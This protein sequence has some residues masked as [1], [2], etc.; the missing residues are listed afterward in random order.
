MLGSCMCGSTLRRSDAHPDGLQPLASGGRRRRRAVRGGARG[1]GCAP[2]A[3]RC[4]SLT[5]GVEGPDVVHTVTPWPYPIQETP[6]QPARR[7]LL[8]HAV[9]VYNPRARRGARRRCSTTLAPDVVHTPRGAGAVERRAHPPPAGTGSRTS[10]R[11]TTTGCSASATRWSTATARPA[12]PAA[13]RAPASPGSATR[14]SAG[15]PRRGARG[16]GG[17]RSRARAARV[18]ARPAPRALQPGRGRG[19][20]RAHARGD[21]RPLTFGFLGRLGVDKGVSTLLDAFARAGSRT[22]AS[23]WP[24]AG[25]SKSTSARRGRA[26]IAAGWVD[27]DA[28][29]GAARRPGLPRRAVGVEGPRAGRGERGAGAG[30]PGHRRGDRRHPR[31]DRARVPRRCCSRP[32]TPARSPTGSRRSRAAPG[33]LPARARGRADRLGRAPRRWSSRPMPTP[34]RRVPV[35]G[36]R[37]RGAEWPRSVAT[38]GA[39]APKIA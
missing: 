32:A 4:T 8:F 3:T 28:Q 35:A 14:R 19:R 34:G 21:G 15:R 13:G 39:L 27:A 25:R 38:Q 29:G 36:H 31:A 37:E 26:V 9:D 33:A 23:S 24:G 10:T 12:R 2:R 11:S 5:L 16:L 1:R 30:H 17:D 18:D 22:P 7:R 20:R 6:T